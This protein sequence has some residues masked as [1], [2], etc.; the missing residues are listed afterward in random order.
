MRWLSSK[1]PAR[2][3][4]ASCREPPALQNQVEAEKTVQVSSTR[5]TIN[6]LE[7]DLGA[8]IREVQ[9]ACDLVRHEAEHSAAATNKI[10][11]QTDSLVVQAGNASRDLSQLAAAIE[12]L[13]RSSD[14]YRRPSAP[15]RQS[16]R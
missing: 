1:R 10:T 8:M 3:D 14:D 9:Q 12:E 13:A 5:E 11:Q 6:L 4:E 16:H 7:A 15:G 2:V